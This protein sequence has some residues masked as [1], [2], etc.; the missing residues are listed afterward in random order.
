M[1]WRW[2]FIDEISMVSAQFLAEID[3]KLRTIMS[4][5]NILKKGKKGQDRPFG[6]L[7]VVFA[8]DFWQLDPPRGGSLSEIPV[9]FI[10]RARQ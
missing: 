10:R 5:A 9:D 4:Q 8:G 2:L 7:N 3:A 1:Q 6:G